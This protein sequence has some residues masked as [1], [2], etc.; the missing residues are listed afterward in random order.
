[1]L[2]HV[3][4]IDDDVDEERVIFCVNPG[5]V[6]WGDAHGGKLD[7]RLDLVPAKVFVKAEPL[8]RP[9]ITYSQ[10][11]VDIFRTECVSFV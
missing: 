7:K 11:K 9:G 6:K 5:I 2:E 1:M 4:E 3:L 8:S 10:S